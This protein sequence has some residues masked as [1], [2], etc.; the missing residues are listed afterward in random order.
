MKRSSQSDRLLFEN[1][2]VLELAN[3]HLGSL[4]RGL[5]IIHD[6]ASIVRYNNV[7]AAI[8]LQFREVDEFIHPDFKGEGTKP[9]WC[10]AFP[11]R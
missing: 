2:F 9:F 10:R 8:K 5:K 4:K 1:L 6:H 3:N 7:K 11:A